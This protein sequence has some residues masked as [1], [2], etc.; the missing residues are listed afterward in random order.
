MHHSMA[1][2][3]SYGPASAIVNTNSP[4]LNPEHSVI[5]RIEFDQSPAHKENSQKKLSF[6]NRVP[7]FHY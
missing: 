5:T 3:L 2:I 7:Y 4:L 6:I 1:I